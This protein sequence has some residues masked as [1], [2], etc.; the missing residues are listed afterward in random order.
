MLFLLL[1][2]ISKVRSSTPDNLNRVA[3][4][5]I[6]E[7]EPLHTSTVRL[8]SESISHGTNGIAGLVDVIHQ[9]TDVP[10]ALTTFFVAV[11]VSE[12][13][14]LFRAVIVCELRK[15]N[16]EN[17]SLEFYVGCRKTSPFA[18][19]SRGAHLKYRRKHGLV[20]G[21]IGNVGATHEI[22]REL[23]LIVMRFAHQFHSQSLVEF[24]RFVGILDT[25]HGL[26][27]IVLVGYARILS[28]FDQLDPVSVR[29]VHKCQSLHSTFVRLLFE[30]A[31][32][33]L[34]LGTC[35]VYIVNTVYVRTPNKQQI[36]MRKDCDPVGVDSCRYKGL[37]LHI[38][39]TTA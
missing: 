39:E 1:L 34:E 13:V 21:T 11:K 17:N 18:N 19:T 20:V 35:R 4:W 14:V 22:E 16:A 25:Q 5:V 38:K 36:F 12:G 27:K 28:A 31:A 7:C 23:G 2:D 32:S 8:F 6:G 3:I 10:K 9:E 24:D 30:A 15:H 37:F 33:R 26:R 29:V